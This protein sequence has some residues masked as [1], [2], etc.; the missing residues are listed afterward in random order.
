M[1]LS[2][3]QSTRNASVMNGIKI[4]VYGRAGMGKTR[5][6]A[7]A[8]NP[9]ILSAESG[10]LS[11]REYDLPFWQINS[12][13]DLTEAF[14]WCQ[15]SHEARQFQ[16]ICLDSLTEIAEQI[17]SNAKAQAKDPRQAYGEL[18]TQM[19][20]TVKK[21]RDLTGFHVYF[22]AKQSM[23]KDDVTG[24][25]MYGPSMPGTKV[26]P[27]LPYLFDE[28]FQLDKGKD[29]QTQQEYH[30]L[31]TSPDFQV[32]AKDRS[33]ALDPFEYPDLGHIINKILGAV[34]ATPQ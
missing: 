7:T 11:I 6:C 10:L 5:L 33:G 2:K 3:L 23:N 22:S 19:I 14:N 16:T 20:D 26:G 9:V 25:S 21:F 28:V 17:L 32:D 12:V 31:R 4:L 30:Y 13:Q 1:S 34:H 15:G 18:L 8:P 27:E 24:R 29:P